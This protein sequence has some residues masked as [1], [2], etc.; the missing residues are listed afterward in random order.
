MPVAVVLAR[1]WW[2]AV[3]RLL[4]VWL[5]LREVARIVGRHLR[6]AIRGVCHRIEAHLVVE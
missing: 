4:R 3:E 2:I 5:L 1:V 6:H